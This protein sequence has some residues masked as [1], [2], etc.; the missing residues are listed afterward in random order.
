MR[1]ALKWIAIL[2]P[3]AMVIG[4][5]I[6]LGYQDPWNEW[7]GFS[8]P[9]ANTQAPLYKT[10]FDWM[11]LLIVPL[12]I[13]IGTLLFNA[14][15]EN[16]QRKLADD[17]QRELKLQWCIDK[18]TTLLIE[19]KLNNNDENKQI[20]AIAQTV[21]VTVLNQLDGARK[22]V[23]L[24]FLYDLFLVDKSN[25]VIDLQHADLQGTIMK[26][27]DL[28]NI[29][30]RGANLS[31][32][33]LRGLK[34]TDADLYGAKFDHADLRDADFKRADLR[35]ATFKYATLTATIFN[36]AQLIEACLAGALLQSADLTDANL[37]DANLEYAILIG[38]ILQSAQLNNVNLQ[39][40]N[41]KG[42][43]LSN[44]S[45]KNSTL[46]GANLT[47]AL[48]LNAVID[49]SI[50]TMAKI[51]R[52]QVDDSSSSVNTKGLDF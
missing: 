11:T 30:L 38:A 22:G 41:L 1:R 12:V 35:E 33:K 2:V 7:T 9:S 17:A 28:R 18:L 26:K 23:L 32:S 15:R 49:G 39:R 21:T 50:F 36:S 46:E 24:Q 43:N 29:Y 16:S 48:L 25:P 27:A 45:L 31:E 8:V 14:R 37:D 4:I 34:F 19:G 51:T 52:E 13:T 40:A 44:V 10:L 47:S 6:W 3:I 5:L 20:R 42:A